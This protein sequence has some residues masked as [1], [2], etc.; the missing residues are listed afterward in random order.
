VHILQLLYTW[1]RSLLQ[2]I[3]VRLLDC[4]TL[5]TMWSVQL[6]LERLH[7]AKTDNMYRDQFL[8]LQP[9]MLVTSIWRSMATSTGGYLCGYKWYARLWSACLSNSFQ[10]HLDGKRSLIFSGFYRCAPR[11][12]LLQAGRTRP[13]RRGKEDHRQIS[14]E[15]RRGPPTSRPADER[16]DW[17]HGDTICQVQ[18]H[19]KHRIL[20]VR[21]IQWQ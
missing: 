3:E 12:T 4:I 16:D 13:P 7:A 19:A 9:L 20:L 6:H 8:P 2:L 15:R 5:F 14:C 21:P 17:Q 10:N 18:A 11:L 1:L